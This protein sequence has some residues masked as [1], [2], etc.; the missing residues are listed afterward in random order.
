MRFFWLVLALAALLVLAWLAGGLDLLGGS[1]RDPGQPDIDRASVAGRAA[2]PPTLVGH[3]GARS[4]GGPGSGAIRG[5]VVQ[6]GEGVVAGVSLR[7]VQGTRIEGPFY[8]VE[9]RWLYEALI[10][11]GDS[12]ASTTSAADGYFAF[13]GVTPGRYEVRASGATGEQASLALEVVADATRADVLLALPSGPPLLRGQARYVDGRPF[14]GFVRLHYGDAM[15]VNTDPFRTDVDWGSGCFPTAADGSFRISGMPTGEVRLAAFVPG[16]RRYVSSPVTMPHAGT[17]EFVVDAGCEVLT[18]EVR[19]LPGDAPVAGARIEISGE[20]APYESVRRVV[21]A[22]AEGRFRVRTPVERVTVRV[23]A[24]H[25]MARTLGHGGTDYANVTWSDYRTAGYGGG[26]R[27]PLVL[28]ADRH[29][30]LRLPRS[31]RVHGMVQRADDG[32]PV[33][34]VPVF[35]VSTA[36]WVASS[37]TDAEGRYEVSDAPPGDVTLFVAG[38]GWITKDLAWAGGRGRSSA[39]RVHLASGGEATLDLEVV[40]A[41]RLRGQVV[42]AEGAPVVRA[43]VRCLPSQKEPRADGFPFGRFSSPAWLG[44]ATTD[45]EGRFAFDTLVPSFP[46]QVHVAHPDHPRHVSAPVR[47]LA[48]GWTEI[49]VALPAT[50]GVDVRVVDAETGKGIPGAR[51]SLGSGSDPC[52]WST[53]QEG[54]AR[55]EPVGTG[56]HTVWARAP[57][58]AGLQRAERLRAAAAGEAGEVRL[59]L[60]RGVWVRGRVITPDALSPA[61]VLVSPS[62]GGTWSPRTAEDGRF[63]CGPVPAGPLELRVYCRRRGHLRALAFQVPV[64]APAD[65][66][67]IDL[68]PRFAEAT[69]DAAARPPR[70]TWTLDVVGPDGDP[71]AHARCRVWGTWVGPGEPAVPRPMRGQTKVVR[72]GKASLQLRVLGLPHEAWIAVWGA[73]DPATGTPV[74]GAVSAQPVPAGGGAVRVVLPAGRVIEGRL[75]WADGTP[76]VGVTVRAFDAAVAESN[77]TWRDEQRRELDLY[78][79]QA[80]AVCDAR[81]VFRLEGLGPGRYAIVPALPPHALIAEVPV[82]AAGSDDVRIVLQRGVA[83]TLT[84]LAPDGMPVAGCDVGV[85]RTDA[86]SPRRV[87]Q[88]TTNGAGR[89]RL[90]GLEARGRYQVLIE[91]SGSRKDLLPA[92]LPDWT[93]QDE[94]VVLEEAFEVSGVVDTVLEPPTN[95]LRVRYRIEGKDEE[96]VF[97][98]LVWARGDPPAF[99]IPDLGAGD[100]LRILVGNP[101]GKS[102]PRA[103]RVAAGTTDLVLPPEERR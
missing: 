56:A 49:E 76:P 64:I 9:P 85:L 100:V 69:E 87:S 95:A 86:S 82:V 68:R 33:A 35:A 42:D 44:A 88:A 50:R 36:G 6:G 29:L 62:L 5:R 74:L 2:G 1:G 25:H 79:A 46:Y 65:D 19:S 13:E 4:L 54:R 23:D 58:Y 91:R 8:R 72:Q 48:S 20:R 47:A 24:P 32:A 63:R 53:D 21:H 70:P 103:L 67:V 78:R 84:V 18:G 31:A 14:R 55:L 80:I 89:A 45:A 77:E 94:T 83:P 90:P 26:T 17:Y 3:P 71:V 102:D 92:D 99:R 28:P 27:D 101:E 66:V 59:A 38:E 30:V 41:A 11:T 15:V 61:T 98:R 40:S 10:G 43:A 97:W 93:P 81:G 73:R 96:R 37:R 52:T 51:V 22:D 57:G 34:G 75:E 60:Q 7:D 16:E 12:L 39:S